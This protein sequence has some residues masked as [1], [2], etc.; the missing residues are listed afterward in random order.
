MRLAALAI[1]VCLLSAACGLGKTA[2]PV[3]LN[4]KNKQVEVPI[5][6]ILRFDFGTA[7]D[8]SVAEAHISFKPAIEGAFTVLP[9]AAALTF[10][11]LSWLE[12]TT[13][14]V[15]ITSFNSLK[16]TPLAA[17]SWSFTTTVVPRVE[18]LHDDSGNPLGP[19]LQVEQGTH[20]T[21]V[22]STPMSQTAT[23]VTANGQPAS[24]TWSAD[25]LSAAIS[26]A[27]M[28]VGRL[29]LAL[30]GGEDLKKHSVI[31]GWQ[32][33]L[34]VAYVVHIATTHLPFP[35]LVQIP[36]DGYGARPQVGV[37]AAA[38]ILEYQTEGGIQ[39]LTGLYTDVP[40]VVGPI[41]SARRISLRL[42]REYHGD[43][44]L[45][46]MSNDL[47]NFLNANP[48]PTTWDNP[49]GFY[50]DSNRYAPNN[51]MLRGDAVL[52]AEHASRVPDFSPLTYGSPDLGPSPT[53]ATSF[54][55]AEHNSTYS[56]DPT[57]GTYQKVE[58]GE[59]MTDASLNKP[60]Q[61]FM[62]LVL[63]TSEFLVPDI[64]N[65]CCTH[66]RDFNLDAGGPLDIF[67]RG[68]HATGSWS[69]ADPNSPL[70]FKNAAGVTLAMPHGLVW[71]DV[72]GS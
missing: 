14:Q 31:P 39:R 19:G 23:T 27:G 68:Q 65:G 58:D 62:V 44:F 2:T 1:T 25:G 53:P 6:Q 21:L 12:G 17:E 4:V 8:G 60:D 7:V 35:A 54:G 71:M 40:A 43:L 3:V 26:T 50:R 48:V 45:S 13:Y 41:R 55:V 67:Y 5:N 59:T 61:I 51:L 11:P 30:T 52:A 18:S 36:N 63:H 38:M 28:A 15:R 16:D 47:H 20:V 29:A 56:Y 37:Q 70:V 10:E 72:V 64:E 24:L 22:F 66:G 69:S 34:D 9:G 32:V 46:G 33:Q 57:T 42:T 49:P